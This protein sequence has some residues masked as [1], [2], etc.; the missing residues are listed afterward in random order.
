MPDKKESQIVDTTGK[1]VYAL[2]IDLIDSTKKGLQFNQSELDR[3][4]LNLVAQIKPYIRKL[5]LSSTLIKFTGDGWIVATEHENEV[6]PLCCLATI[7]ASRFQKDMSKETG[8][9]ID[10]IPSLRL[11][12]CG[13]RDIFVNLPD[14]R[15]DWVGDS[16]R[17]AN[18]AI[19]NCLPNQILIDYITYRWALRDFKCEKE[20]IDAHPE[21]FKATKKEED[22]ILYNLGD[23]KI[24]AAKDLEAPECFIYTFQF[25]GKSSAAKELHQQVLVSSL[26][27]AKKQ[28]INEDSRQSILI[29]LNRLISVNPFF[30]NALKILKDIKKAGL[31]PNI[32]TYNMLIHKSP[33][34]ALAVS[35]F[36]EMANENVLPNEVT[37]STIIRKAPYLKL[38]IIWYKRMLN[39]DIKPNVYTYNA[40]LSKTADI[41]EAVYWYEEMLKND[42]SA[43]SIVFNT[44]INKT[45]DL[46]EAESWFN[47]M[48]DENISP[49]VHTYIALI[50]HS[51]NLTEARVWYDRL[52]A[53]ELTPIYPLYLILLQ[54]ASSYAQASEFFKEEIEKKIK[55]NAFIY[56][57]LLN[58][59]PEFA[60]AIKIYEKMIKEKIRPNAITFNS[61]INKAP[62]LKDANVWRKK[63]IEAKIAPKTKTYNFLIKKASD[64]GKGEILLSEMQKE[65]LEP[66]FYTFQ[67]LFNLDLSN[68]SADK[69]LIWFLKRKYHPEKVIEYA[70][71]SYRTSQLT[72]QALR[73]ALDYPHLK[74]SRK[75]MRDYSKES[76]LYYKE[77]SESIPNH[78]S[79]DYALGIA[80][81][82]G[83]KGFKA[84]SHLK[85]ALKLATATKRK[86]NIKYLL[87]TIKKTSVK[88]TSS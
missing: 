85:N 56:N 2:N 4:N 81:I 60:E 52:I 44:I 14:G 39:K 35:W 73:L 33:N 72:K 64:F 62:T 10:K 40:L 49:D 65:G 88:Q 27:E 80:L 18:R 23:L 19:G 12:I 77:I 42:V 28:N 76:I 29:K 38:A 70:I 34:Y 15:G 45:S 83:G 54:K 82:E 58:C 50:K 11:A 1:I 25:L 7:M 13:G 47:K 32:K 31:S 78:P 69:L 48:F 53:S 46:K 51:S 37:Y 36:K 8:I 84:I 68:I 55:T 86:E 61:M 3:F 30:S 75:L 57:V 71:A 67:I 16:I 9:P 43:N 20:N 87:R 5:K 21:K 59:N 41:K 26:N 22:L 17:C 24:E 6:I 79:A 63:M 74:E 66:N